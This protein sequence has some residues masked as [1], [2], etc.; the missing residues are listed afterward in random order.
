M[1]ANKT[2]NSSNN[3]LRMILI[4]LFLL[5]LAI[6]IAGYYWAQNAILQPV[7]GQIVGMN[8]L[9]PGL[10]IAAIGRTLLHLL[11]AL[12]LAFIA[13]GSGRFL[14]QRI[15]QLELNDLEE[16]VFGLGVGFGALG[17]LVFFLGIVGL[18]FPWL[19]YLVTAVLTVFVGRPTLRFLRQLPRPKPSRLITIFLALSLFLALTRALLPPTDWDGLFY[20]LTGPRL[21]LEAGRILSG[22]DIPHLNFPAL[23]EMLFM[24][25]MGMV[26]DVPAVL[27]HFIFNLMTAGVVYLFARDLLGVKNGWLGVLFYY[28]MPMVLTLAGWAYNDLGLA[29]YETAALYCLLKAAKTYFLSKTGFFDFDIGWLILSAI[30]SGMAMSMKYTSFVAPLALVILLLWWKRR[31]LA[32]AVRPLFLFGI[33]AFLVAV[34]W[35]VKNLAFTGN[36]VYPF[37]FGGEYWDDFRADAYSEAGTGIAYNPESCTTANQVFLIGQHVTGCQVDIGYLAVNLLTMPYVLT[38]G[39][40]DANLVDGI[41]GPLFL[42]F[43]P[44]LVAY[45]LTRI[46]RRKPAVF[47]AMLFF[48]LVQFL[49]W[50]VGVISSAPLW[51][52]RLLLPAFVV[53]CP[54]LAWIYE[55]MPRFDFANFSLHRQINLIFGLVLVVGLLIQFANWLPQQPWT[56]L[57]GNESRDDNLLRRLGAN[58]GA[59]QLIN[60]SVGPDDVV[61]FLWE[62]RSYYCDGPECR[63]DSILDRFGH[64]QYLYGDADSIVDSWRAE[65]ITHVLLFRSGLKLIL[66]NNSPFDQ[67]L[68]EPA[69]LTEILSQRLELVDTVGNDFYELYRLPPDG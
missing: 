50:T 7:I 65:G 2:K 8:W 14:L 10:S 27:L 57:I 18:L 67:P 43:L 45:S 12:W 1:A 39:L 53:L 11:A 5:W 62:P 29:F 32:Q 30:F 46:G 49:F 9:F 28:A 31:Q 55:D 33:L 63:P 23:F 34:P 15:P 64:L 42:L 41:S 3:N 52:S 66:T 17:L 44:L 20:H 21:Y 6:S 37:V 68:A 47:N 36:P 61:L 48:A 58:Y 35:Y 54:L 40:R 26:G 25:A 19:F 24:L 56:Y 38:L 60:D 59:M 51:Q 13:L 4:V 69:V 22:I 16:V